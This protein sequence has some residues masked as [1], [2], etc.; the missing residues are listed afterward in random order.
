MTAKP[1]PF[2]KTKLR[3]VAK[4]LFLENG[5]R[6]PQGL[7]TEPRDPRIHAGRAA[8]GQRGGIDPS[9]SKPRST[10]AGIFSA[11]LMPLP[12]RWRSAGSSREGDRRGYVA[13]TVGG[14]R[15]SSPA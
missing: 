7:W 13:V 2:F 11:A 14:Q 1:L 5:W 12:L 15:F 6:L 3:D 8:A 4:Q 9:K 10:N